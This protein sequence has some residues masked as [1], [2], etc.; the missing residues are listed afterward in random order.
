ML[1][2]ILKDNPKNRFLIIAIVI[3]ATI[4]FI[5]KLNGRFWLNDFKV[6]YSAAEALLNYEQVYGKSFGLSTGFYKYSPFSLLLFIPYTLVPYE[7][8]SVIHFLLIGFCAVT[9]IIVLEQIISK[10][11][12]TYGKKHYLT[13]LSILLCVML[14]LVRELHLGNIN[15]VM[16]FLLS[17]SLKFGLE[18]KPIKSGILLSIVIL[19]KPYFIICVLPFL[20]HRRYKEI[21]TTVVSGALCVLTSVVLIGFSKSIILYIEWFYA[22]LEHSNYLM[23]NHTIFS[24]IHHYIGI[25]IPPNYALYLLGIVG[26]LSCLYFWNLTRNEDNTIPLVSDYGPLI[27]HYFL[28]ISIIPNLLIT[29]TE[30]FLFSLPLITIIVLYLTKEKRILWN[31]LFVFLI[32]LYEGNMSDLLGK[33]LSG[34]FDDFG[35]LGISNLII[36]GVVIFLYSRNKKNWG[37]KISTNN[38]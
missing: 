1:S 5:E 24:L 13:L 12:F 4:L 19:T 34:K 14:H 37:C 8:A 27:I 21:S 33:D 16:L 15:M 2:K 35:L 29:D 25:L 30:H 10:Y 36:I 11:L 28:L 7:I 23:S 26:L 32:F 9:T 17:L 38:V 20:L 22:M 6:F 18:A 31:V 3:I